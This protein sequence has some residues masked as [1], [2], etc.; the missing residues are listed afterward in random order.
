MET[1]KV[2]RW[3]AA[4]TAPPCLIGFASSEYCGI[5]INLRLLHHNKGVPIQ[6]ISAASKLTASRNRYANELEC[7][8]LSSAVGR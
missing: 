3:T 2:F 5:H 4:R 7:R 6:V 8:T 1:L